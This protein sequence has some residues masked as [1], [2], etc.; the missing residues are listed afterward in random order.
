MITSFLILVDQGS[1]L[2][3]HDVVNLQHNSTCIRK[4][5]LDG[6][7]DVAIAKKVNRTRANVNLERQ[8]LIKEGQVERIDRGR[9]TTTGR[10]GNGHDA[11]NFDAVMQ[12]LMEALAAKQREPE[13]KAELE[14]FKRGYENMKDVATALEK[15]A[16]K[17]TN[18]LV[19]KY[20]KKF[21]NPYI[22]AE[23]GYIDDII[24][25][26]ETR[27]R[28][29]NALHTLLNKREDRPAKKHGNI[30]L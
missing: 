11:P 16:K 20:R 17:K 10:D 2:L 22:A 3:T 13:L 24:E 28:L 5:I 8:K 7:S 27:P 12:F 29:I 1:D 14:K 9:P 25:P 23:M 30:P 26:Q 21:A 4:L 19:T 6:Y 15:D 18:E